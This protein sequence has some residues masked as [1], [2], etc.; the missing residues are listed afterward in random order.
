MCLIMR[1]K[2]QEWHDNYECFFNDNVSAGLI[3]IACIYP[4]SVDSVLFK[5]SNSLEYFKKAVNK[6]II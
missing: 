4:F 2:S 1:W 6:S 3:D 5:Y